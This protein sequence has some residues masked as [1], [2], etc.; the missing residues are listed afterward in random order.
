[1]KILSI[2]QQDYHQAAQLLSRA[3]VDDPVSVAIYRNFPA[4]K[5]IHALEVD[6]SAEL[7]LCLRRGYPIQANENGRMVA[8]AVIY[9]PGCYPFPLLD[10]WMLLVKSILGNGWYDVRAWMKWLDEVDRQHPK[11]THYYLEYIGVTPQDQGKGYGTGILKY[12]STQ[13][14]ARRM[15]CYLENANPRNLPFYQ[16]A[17]FQVIAERQIIGLPTWFMW[18]PSNTE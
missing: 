9:P 2:T 11:I 18:R 16:Q 8:V 13:A 12:L 4:T 6:F 1:M 14:D 15:G 3:F 5:R 17:G 7:R 10:Q